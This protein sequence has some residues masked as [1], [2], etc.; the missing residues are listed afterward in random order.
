MINIGDVVVYGTNGVCRFNGTVK[1]KTALGISEYYEFEGV[2]DDTNKMYLPKSFSI[3]EKVRAV[4]SH[5]EA[6]EV[7][8]VV[9]KEEVLVIVGDEER[10]EKLSDM[11]KSNNS[12]DAVRVVRSLMS[13]QKSRQK[14]GNKLHSA[15]ERMLR[16][17]KK[18]VDDE[19]SYSLEI[20]P[21]DV[22]DF[23]KERIKD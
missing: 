10:R 22:A 23:I 8:D 9:A 21:E 2:R 1:K 6:S 18:M 5:N 3:E 14:R 13:L 16:L 19:L 15:D 12:A 4:M 20:A 17:A 11:L 7:V